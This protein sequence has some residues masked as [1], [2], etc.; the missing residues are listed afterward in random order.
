V[1][2]CGYNVE[3]DGKINFFSDEHKN[4]FRAWV[5][6]YNET[7]KDEVIKRRIKKIL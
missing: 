7:I 6:L 3:T 4:I 1:S 5:E 2:Q